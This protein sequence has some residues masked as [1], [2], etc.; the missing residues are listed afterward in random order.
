MKKF[1]VVEK[2]TADIDFKFEHGNKEKIHRY[3]FCYDKNR[4]IECMAII[5][6]LDNNPVDLTIEISNMYN[7]PVGC[8][9]CA[10][11]S[12]PSKNLYLSSEDYLIQVDKALQES[13]IDYKD[14]PKFYVAFTGIGEP[15]LVKEEI[16]K[17]IKLIKQKYPS[18][19]VNIATTGFDNTCFAYWDKLNLPIRYFQLPYYSCEKDKIK[20]IIQNLPSNYDLSNNL[21]EAI[22]YKNNHKECKIK[23][24]FVV[25]E[26]MND[27]EEDIT[28]MINYLK[29]YKHDIII[30]VS[31]LNYT[32]KC[33]E[34]N[35]HSP[36]INKMNKILNILKSS[37]FSCY[38]FGS[39]KNTEL[40]CGQLVQ[41]YICEENN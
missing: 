17:G 10:S 35:L 16:A 1:D 2:I 14:Y 31:F 23:L 37:G 26:G 32:E 21:D 15:S 25:I 4:I 3:L 12:L 5:H 24:N 38:L 7:C 9:F 28:K 40:G 19:E 13:N 20:Y 36:S 33:R 39:A 8:R 30:K 27:S 29:K 18:V 22:K 41:N 34:N 11:G 6:Y